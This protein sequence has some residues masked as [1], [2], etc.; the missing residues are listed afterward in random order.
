VQR[1]LSHPMLGRLAKALVER[2]KHSTRV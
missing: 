1:G 2:A